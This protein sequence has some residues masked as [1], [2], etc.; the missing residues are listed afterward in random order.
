M[1]DKEYRKY[2][3]ACAK[4]RKENARLLADFE[5]WLSDK[6]LAEKTIGQ[7][8]A[9]AEF[10]LNTFLLYSAAVPAKKGALELS[11][12]LGDWFIRKAIWAS[13]TS[14]KQIAASLK[15]FYTFMHEQG[16]IDTGDLQDLKETVKEEMPDWLATLKHYDD[17]DFTDPMEIWRL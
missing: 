10:Y 3:R 5:K 16:H 7:H 17:Q 14:I 9:N 8:A 6:A 11:S 12:F 2:E 4:I 1:S 13:P 15:K